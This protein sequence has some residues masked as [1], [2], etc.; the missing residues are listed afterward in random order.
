MF[1]R[2]VAGPGLGGG[3]I[4]WSPV[5][6]DLPRY[7][8]RCR[9]R[10][11]TPD[12]SIRGASMRGATHSPGKPV[13]GL[14]SNIQRTFRRCRKLP[15]FRPAMISMPSDLRRGR[16]IDDTYLMSTLV[17]S[18]GRARAGR[19]PTGTG[20]LVPSCWSNCPPATQTRGPAVG[21]PASCIF[22]R[23][24]GCVFESLT[25]AQP[26]TRATSRGAA[27]LSSP[28]NAQ[29]HSCLPSPATRQSPSQCR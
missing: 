15:Q 17:R 7:H 27:K 24:L 29:T 21:L 19:N 26:A 13:H 28:S 2:A 20:P 11:R 8:S 1:P 5:Q 10:Q 25:E 22:K 16:D 18:R 23:S 12:R 6:L 4:D 3:N 9:K 14:P